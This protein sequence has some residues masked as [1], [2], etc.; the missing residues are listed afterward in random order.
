M[1]VVAQH[2]VGAQGVTSVQWIREAQERFEAARE[3]L[4]DST[5]LD[6]LQSDYVKLF[7]VPGKDYVRPWESV[8]AGVNPT[9]FQESTLEVR[10]FY[11]DAGFRLAAERHFPDDHIGAMM[12][13]MGHQAMAAYDAFADGDDGSAAQL[14]AVQRDFLQSH[15]LTWG[16]DFAVE[17]MEHDGSGYYG[18]AAVA[19]AVFARADEACLGPIIDELKA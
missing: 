6:G 19:M 8:Y 14:L 17:V 16:D 13:F 18:T 1:Q 10:A 9:M 12:D 5:L 2:P 4:D 11:H 15:V 7:Q 3:Q